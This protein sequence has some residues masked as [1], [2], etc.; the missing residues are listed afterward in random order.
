MADNTVTLVLDG[1]VPLAEFAKGVVAFNELVTALADEVSRGQVKWILDDLQYSSAIATARG[2][3]P[4]IEVERAIIAYADVGSS[5]ESHSKLKYGNRVQNAAEKVVNIDVERVRF[6]T[7]KT[8]ALIPIV[9]SQAAAQSAIDA[10]QSLQIVRSRKPAFG[11]IK[12]R[13]QTLTSRGRLRF[14]LYDAH[15]DKAVSCYFEEGKQS[16][17]RDLWGKLAIVE[18]MIYRDPVNGRPLTIRE[19]S[20]ITPLPEPTGRRDFEQ[21]MGAAPSLYGMSAEE[22][23]RKVRDAQ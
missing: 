23:I 3:G 5:L 20:E 17:V 13:I 19:V 8:D 7:S 21:A 2:E 16:Q 10:G 11:G 1:R 14:T 22:A 9:Q 4:D 15:Q 6:E 12:G 18:G